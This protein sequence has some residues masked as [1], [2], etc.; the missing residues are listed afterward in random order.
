M[1][2]YNFVVNSFLIILLFTLKD[3]KLR[4]CIGDQTDIF[5]RNLLEI[6]SW[7]AA[8]PMLVWLITSVANKGGRTAF[9]I[10]LKTM[11]Y[12]TIS[13]ISQTGPSIWSKFL[14][15]LKFVIVY[16]QLIGNVKFCILYLSLGACRNRQIVMPKLEILSKIDLML[17]SFELNQ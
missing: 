12:S 13:P 1:Q 14:S 3:F 15:F 16:H 11:S 8:C 2:L 7:W 5:P 6:K 10:T 4:F 9:E 17:V